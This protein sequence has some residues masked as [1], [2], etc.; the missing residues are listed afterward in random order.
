MSSN[1]QSVSEPSQSVCEPSQ[2]GC[3]CPEPCSCLKICECVHDEHESSE[4]FDEPKRSLKSQAV[5]SLMK[6]GAPV[7]GVLVVGFGLLRL[8]KRFRSQ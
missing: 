5:Y 7:V 4:D 8:T 1:T 3:P 6:Y 2:C